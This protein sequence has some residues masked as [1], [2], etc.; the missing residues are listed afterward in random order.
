MRH[1]ERIGIPLSVGLRQKKTISANVLW[2]IFDHKV[3]YDYANLMSR[4]SY[5]ES[6]L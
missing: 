5:C 3:A 1:E 4:K 2:N 6:K